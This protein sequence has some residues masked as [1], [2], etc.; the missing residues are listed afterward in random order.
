[1]EQTKEKRLISKIWMRVLW[2]E[3]KQTLTPTTKCNKL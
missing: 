2:L 3:Q 1:M